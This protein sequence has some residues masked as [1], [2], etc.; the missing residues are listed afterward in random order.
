M[1]LRVLGIDHGRVEAAVG[2]GRYEG[3]PVVP[4]VVDAVP[5]EDGLGQDAGVGGPEVPE[6]SHVHPLIDS[7]GHV[8]ELEVRVVLLVR[9]DD[10]LGLA[11]VNHVGTLGAADEPLS[12]GT[13]KMSAVLHVHG[14]GLPDGVPTHEAGGS[15]APH[16]GSGVDDGIVLVGRPLEAIR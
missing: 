1:D 7:E 4:I 15:P 16:P 5:A 3:L 8:I 13:T 12:Q 6:H 14:V 11:P 2:S 9:E 10:G